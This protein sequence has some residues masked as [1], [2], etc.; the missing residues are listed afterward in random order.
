[1]PSAG[2]LLPLKA[3]VFE[4]LLALLRSDSHGYALMGSVAESTGRQVL[5]GSFYRDLEGMEAQGLIEEVDPRVR[6]GRRRRSFRATTFGRDVA[7]AERDRM[8]RL[9]QASADLVP[10]SDTGR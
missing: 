1:M 9:V 2:E 4:I 7:A 5:P 10:G 3:Q 6:E 8:Q